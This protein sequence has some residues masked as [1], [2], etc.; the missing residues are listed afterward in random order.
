VIPIQHIHPMLVHFPIV[1]IYLL[2]AIDLMALVG[3]S[4][5]TRISGAGTISTFVAL[6]A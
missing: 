4:A 1:L 6:A 3:G 2:V 5:V